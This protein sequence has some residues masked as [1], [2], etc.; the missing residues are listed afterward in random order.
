MES[1][2]VNRL[3][4]CLLGL[5]R[6]YTGNGNPLQC[7]CLE[8]P[9]DRWAWWAAISG[10]AQ[11]RTQLKLLS[12]RLGVKKISPPGDTDRASSGKGT[13]NPRGI[14]L[15]R[16]VGFDY[17]TYTGLGKQMFGRHEQNLVCP[18]TQEK[19]AMTPKE[20]EPDLPVSVQETPAQARVNSGLL[21]GQGHWIQ[22]SWELQHA[23]RSP[24][25]GDCHYQAIVWPEAKLQ[26]GN[27]APP[28]N[29]KL[30]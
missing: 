25:E 29:R 9:R 18:R 2:L 10:A 8:N 24:F 7:S 5:S 14:W 4:V 3:S 28:I 26:G 23:G 21:W 6:S 30:D 20:K 17:R 19:G 15:W 27:T 13:E 12:S 16:P 1:L 22:Q 11:C